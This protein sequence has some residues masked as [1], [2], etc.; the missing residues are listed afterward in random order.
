MLLLALWLVEHFVNATGVRDRGPGPWSRPVQWLGGQQNPQGNL[1][2]RFFDLS[3]SVF[4]GALLPIQQNTQACLQ[5][6][7]LC[8][9]EAPCSLLQ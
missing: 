7:D 9:I 8:E 6:I 5:T 1:W 2:V 4:L 3:V